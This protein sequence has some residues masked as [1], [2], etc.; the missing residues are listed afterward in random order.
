MNAKKEQ[1]V[2]AALHLFVN[3]GFRQTSIQD[4]IDMA[5]VAKG[6]FYNYFKSKNE[7]LMAI[8]EYVQEK[9]DKRR[10]EL[11]IGK[12]KTDEEVFIHQVAV[13]MNMNREYNL[14]SLFES[15]AFSSD[16]TFNNFMKNQYLLEINWVSKRL[17]DMYENCTEKNSVDLAIILL[18]INHHF[19]HVAKLLNE[20]VKIEE[21][22][23]YSLQRLKL[24]IKN[25]PMNEEVFFSPILF[26]QTNDKSVKE[27]LQNH[28][29]Q[30]L[31]NVKENEVD[32]RAE[33]YIQF[34]LDE[35]SNENPQLYVMESV[36]ESLKKI[37]DSDRYQEDVRHIIQLFWKWKNH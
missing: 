6:T 29:N 34:L 17:C 4:I 7:C 21:V 12:K 36:S 20:Q 16:E 8:M 37:L 23:K 32:S 26:Q 15:V 9:G 28:L 13:R 30:L 22:I 35:L 1:I 33:E 24:I 31:S 11:A 27:E 25:Q 18:S 14:L 5:N 3:K 2:N 10:V 19:L